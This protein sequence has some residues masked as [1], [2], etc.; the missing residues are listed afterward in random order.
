[1]EKRDVPKSGNAC[2]FKLLTQVLTFSFLSGGRRK[3]LKGIVNA[4][5]LPTQKNYRTPSD[6][7][8]HT[9]KL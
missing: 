6:R 2:L 8:S 4:S 5:L 1:M 9:L 7:L 3:N